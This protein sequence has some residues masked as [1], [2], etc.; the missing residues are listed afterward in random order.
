MLLKKKNSSEFIHP[1][2]TAAK[3]FAYEPNGLMMDYFSREAESQEYAA[4]EFTINHRNIK[5]RVAKITPTKVGQFVTLWKRIGSGPIQPFDMEDR[6][7][8]FVISVRS[9]EHFGQFV[10]QKV[11]CT[12]KELYPRMVKGAREP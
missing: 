5:Y 1:D 3:K 6:V 7:D 2:L 10:S 12:K 9:S 4:S 11:Y 8:L